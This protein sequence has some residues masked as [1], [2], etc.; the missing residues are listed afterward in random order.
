MSHKYDS[1]NNDLSHDLFFFLQTR[2]VSGTSLAVQ[3]LGLQTS[4]VGGVGSILGQGRSHL[5]CD[6]AK[7]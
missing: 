6:A 7:K 1:K 4:I 3:W 5:L 2:N